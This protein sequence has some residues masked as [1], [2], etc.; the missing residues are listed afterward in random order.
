M[1]QFISEHPGYNIIKKARKEG[2]TYLGVSLVSD[3]IPDNIKLSLTQNKKSKQK[4]KEGK[5]RKHLQKAQRKQEAIKLRETI[6]QRTGWTYHEYIRVINMRFI[7]IYRNDIDYNIMAMIEAARVNI[8]N[9]IYHYLEPL[10]KCVHRALFIKNAIEKAIN[11]DLVLSHHDNYPI[12]TQ[13]LKVA[14]DVYEPYISLYKTI[15]L[16]NKFTQGFPRID[17]IVYPNIQQLLD[18]VNW[19]GQ[20]NEREIDKEMAK[21]QEEF[22]DDETPQGVNWTFEDNVRKHVKD[23]TVT[24]EEEEDPE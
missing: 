1:L 6:C 2:T 24:E 15:Q 11:E 8:R 12:Y 13:R 16:Y 17:D 21:E 4:D 9:Y 20:H 19:L 3:S 5:E 10:Y 23:E 14:P 7:P 22:E 18:L